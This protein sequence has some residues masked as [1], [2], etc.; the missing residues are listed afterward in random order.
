MTEHEP[1]PDE[2]AA[3]EMERDVEQLEE[4]TARLEAD[5][6]HAREDWEAKKRDP[7]VPGAA[8]DPERAQG[9][10]P[11]GQRYPTKGDESA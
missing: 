11:P 1:R 5:I 3:R 10:P 8:G 2:R 9:G 7:A 6:E 4:R